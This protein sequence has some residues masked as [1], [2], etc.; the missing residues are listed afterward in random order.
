MLDELQSLFAQLDSST[1]STLPCFWDRPD[2]VSF[3]IGLDEGPQIKL[4]PINPGTYYLNVRDVKGNQAR[5]SID[6]PSDLFSVANEVY[7]RIR[8]LTN[9]PSYKIL[10]DEPD[11]LGLMLANV[12]SMVKPILKR[13]LNE[14]YIE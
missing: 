14:D 7:S 10:L 1:L 13:L 4:Y 3:R 9:A 6:S 8:I 2:T 5:F 11:K 12:D